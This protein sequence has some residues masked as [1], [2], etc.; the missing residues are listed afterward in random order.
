MAPLLLF[1]ILRFTE[2]LSSLTLPVLL[3]GGMVH[4][5]HSWEPK[6]SSPEP[7]KEIREAESTMGFQGPTGVGSFKRH[8]VSAE[9]TRGPEDGIGNSVVSVCVHHVMELNTSNG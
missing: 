5:P 1:S 6:T 8:S 9:K 7:E 2:S 4:L 3:S